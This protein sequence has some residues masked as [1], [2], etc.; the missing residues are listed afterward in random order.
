MRKSQYN[1]RGKN[2][3]RTALR[4]AVLGIAML[5][6][7]SPALAVFQLSLP[8][9]FSDLDGS[10]DDNDG[11]VNGIFTRF[12]DFQLL[13]GGSVT[14]NDL[15]V[16]GNSALPMYFNIGGNMDLF[17]GSSLFA[18]NRVGG[19]SGA[20]INLTIGGNLFLEGTSGITAGAII[21][22]SK[23]GGSGGTGIAGSININVTG[24]IYTGAGSQVLANSTGSAGAINMTADS[25]T[26]DGLVESRSSLTGTGAQQAPGGGP[27]SLVALCRLTV[28]DTGKISSRGNDPGAD[29]VHLEGCDVVI[30]GLVESAGAGHAVP[31]NPINHLNAANRPDKSSNSTGGVEVWAGNSLIIDNT[32][33]H[34]GE[35]NADLSV[36]AAGRSWIDLIARK[37]IE[38]ISDGT[39]NF[40]VHATNGGN[41][42][43]GGTIQLISLEGNIQASGKAIDASAGGS[44]FPDGGSI[45]LVAFNDI[46]LDAAELLATG[47][48]NP[49]GG[50]G[51]GGQILMHAMNGDLFWLGG[52]GDVRPIAGGA[53]G[54]IDLVYLGN[55]DV[56]GTTFNAGTGGL[57]T[58]LQ[59]L[60]G[61]SP[62]LQS[63]VE[64]SD[65]CG[66][67]I[68]EPSTAL[69]A[70]L[71]CL[72]I[73]A[74][75]RRWAI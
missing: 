38:L 72:S 37:D 36:G 67:L 20:E 63:Y 26:V 31:N 27:I 10:V 57:V 11:L 30:Y 45:S 75:R 32:G 43:T 66:C 12:D 73:P 62:T 39:G 29:L 61:G 21:S 33:T 56:T 41:N 51:N 64:L 35:I 23:I 1:N 49:S 24:D 54:T 60:N 3:L 13:D 25:I 74:F 8:T 68:P 40:L 22:S 42:P 71:A 53:P 18:E 58:L 50:L 4:S 46:L 19:G 2:H 15:G 44:G 7:V 69:L 52:L 47:D 48:F 5:S 70:V 28:G 16:S 59:D 6:C 65:D 34:N 17:A 14:H 9:I 55:I